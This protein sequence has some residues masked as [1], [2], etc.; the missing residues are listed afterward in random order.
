[1]KFVLVIKDSDVAR[2]RRAADAARPRRRGDR[3]TLPSA[4]APCICPRPLLARLGS[5]G[6]QR[7]CLLLGTSGLNMRTASLTGFDPTRTSRPKRPSCSE[8]SILRAALTGAV[9]QPT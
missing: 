5:G 8:T 3:I 9:R 1:T 6:T 4:H 7:L 2:P